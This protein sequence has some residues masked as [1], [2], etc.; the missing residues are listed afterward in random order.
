MGEISFADVFR[1]KLDLA[2]LVIASLAA[3]RADFEFIARDRND[4]E[5][6]EIN[7]IAGVSDDRAHVAGEK[8]L[9]LTD[10]EHE[11]R[12]APRTNHEFFDVGMNERDAV[13]ADHL[14]KRSTSGVD[15]ARFGIDAVNFLINAAD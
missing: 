1:P 13:S 4:I 10:A 14:F 11:G 5:I 3:D 8:I 6:V 12:T 2:D 9:I 7:G 15:Q